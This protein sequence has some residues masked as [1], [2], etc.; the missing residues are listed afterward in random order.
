M[1]SRNMRSLLGILILG[2]GWRLYFY[3]DHTLWAKL[4]ENTANRPDLAWMIFVIGIYSFT[5]LGLLIIR[6]HSV[7]AIAMISMSATLILSIGIRIF[8]PLQTYYIVFGLLGVTT[9]LF[10][11]VVVYYGSSGV[12]PEGRLSIVALVVL[13]FTV[14]VYALTY[15]AKS[16]G[17]DIAFVIASALMLVSIL[18]NRTYVP[19][20]LASAKDTAS[21]PFPTKL[22]VASGLTIF[23]GYFG[24]YLNQSGMGTQDMWFDNPPMAWL[25]F[26]VRVA[27]CVFF[28][29]AGRRI[30]IVHTLYVCQACTVLAFATSMLNMQTNLPAWILYSASNI[31]G[32][33]ALYALISAVA[34][35]YL[36]RPQTFALLLL[37]TG[38]GIVFGYVAGT[39]AHRFFRDDPVFFRVIPLIIFCS[40]FFVSP[41]IIRAIERE[42]D[43]DRGSTPGFFSESLSRIPGNVA[44][45]EHDVI[46]FR[47]RITDSLTAVNTMFEKEYRLTTREM[48]IASY[49]AERYD[50]ETIVGK[51][52]ISVNTLKAHI[53]NIYRKYDIPNRKSLVELIERRIDG[54]AAG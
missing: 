16:W 52:F 18:L 6:D 15:V 50:Y 27:I 30:K 54:K 1:F 49:L 23:V 41:F 32:T 53:K 21:G 35:K 25:G 4:V 40:C 10:N 7:K 13:G 48:E 44:M 33:I 11:A 5:Y 8:V 19:A 2:S 45:R 3:Y 24:N 34:F 29:L 26:L 22:V 46:V 9:G 43:L 20:S 12:P 39:A 31:V 28:L 38:A 51:L 47:R 36:K 42:V 17:L 37:L 14:I